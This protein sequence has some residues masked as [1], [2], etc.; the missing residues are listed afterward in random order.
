[1]VGLAAEFAISFACEG[2]E[3]V[4]ILHLPS[5]SPRAGVVVVVGGPQY[6]TGSH[7]QFTL[8]ARELAAR[9]FAVLR[10]DC[11]GMGDSDGEFPG[12]EHVGPDVAAAVAAIFARVPT[13]R[14]VGLWGLCDATLAMCSHARRDPR[15]AGLVL[16]NPWVRSAGGHARVQLKHY[17]LARLMHPGLMRRLL[18]GEINPIKSARELLGTILRSFG[19]SAPSL[20]AADSA[21]NFLAEQMAI[22]LQDFSG[23]VLIILSGRDLTAREF[24]DAMRGSKRWQQLC[25]RESVSVLRLPEADHTFSRQ[26]W[27]KQVS[28]WTSAWIER[29]KP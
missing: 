7:R 2:D 8:L 27:R 25:A 29:W 21:S 11:R 19:A 5:P 14:Q 16:L 22:D 18:R 1:M 15:V 13:L 17:Y 12:F 10:F 28:A 23:D 6:R 20:P 26:D 4:G 24:E 3:L 9:G